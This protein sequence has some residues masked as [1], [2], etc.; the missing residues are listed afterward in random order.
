MGERPVVITREYHL[1]YNSG[2]REFNI[3]DCSD[4]E[5]I[6]KLRKLTRRPVKDV[7]YPLRIRARIGCT[8]PR[9]GKNLYE[10]PHRATVPPLR[11]QKLFFKG[12]YSP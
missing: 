10:S 11:A 9:G 5:Q 7:E 2:N 12:V 8:D 6:C 1:C 3:H 4:L